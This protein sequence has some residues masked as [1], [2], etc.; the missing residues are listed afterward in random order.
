MHNLQLQVR[1]SNFCLYFPF[2]NNICL[3]QLFIVVCSVFYLRLIIS[4]VHPCVS[5]GGNYGTAFLFPSDCFESRKHE[6]SFPCHTNYTFFINLV[7]I[8]SF[9]AQ[10]CNCNVFLWGLTF[11]SFYQWLMPCEEGYLEAEGL[12]KTWRVK[13]ED[14]LKEVDMNSSRK[15][16]DMI[17]PGKIIKPYIS[18]NPM[19]QLSMLHGFHL[20]FSTLAFIYISS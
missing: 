5:Y 11:L 17:L 13:Q 2:S 20:I 3:V 18:C 8:D 19:Q 7:L 10:G 16:F 12:E 15:P 4:I 9:I 14:I 1:Y 6:M